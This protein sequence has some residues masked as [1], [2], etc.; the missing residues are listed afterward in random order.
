M[1]IFAVAR[2]KGYRQNFERNRNKMGGIGNKGKKLKDK[3]AKNTKRGR[4]K[5][6][7]F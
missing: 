1:T 3:K 2:I 7:N 6:S 4:R 5:I